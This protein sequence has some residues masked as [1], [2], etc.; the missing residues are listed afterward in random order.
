[1]F[2]RSYYIVR[3]SIMILDCVQSVIPTLACLLFQAS[4]CLTKF[5]SSGTEEQM[6]SSLL[7]TRYDFRVV[8]KALP[9]FWTGI[10]GSSDQVLTYRYHWWK[11]REKEKKKIHRNVFFANQLLYGQYFQRRNEPAALFLS[12]PKRHL[13]TCMQSYIMI[14]HRSSSSRRYS[15]IE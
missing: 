1:M 10:L 11:K 4:I 2:S 12:T 6:K 14:Y 13:C 8:M 15:S 7:D 5:A 3:R 9:L